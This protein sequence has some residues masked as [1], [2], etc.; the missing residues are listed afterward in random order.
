MWR[1]SKR[2]AE[3]SG[4]VVVLWRS[5]WFKV[6]YFLKKPSRSVC[7]GWASTLQYFIFIERQPV[8]FKWLPALVAAV[9]LLEHLVSSHLKPDGVQYQPISSIWLWSD[10]ISTTCLHRNNFFLHY[11]Q[12]QCRF[13]VLINS[14]CPHKQNRFAF[15]PKNWSEQ[16]LVDVRP[17]IT[18]RSCLSARS[19]HDSCVTCERRC[20]LDCSSLSCLAVATSA[21]L[22]IRLTA[23]LSVH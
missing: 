3:G 18:A 23:P 17:R 20:E 10:G 12:F 7:Q 15:S 8:I 2:R 9:K 1:G 22:I 21:P 6:T 4:Q 5:R 16:N 19:D 13:T 14:K 11:S